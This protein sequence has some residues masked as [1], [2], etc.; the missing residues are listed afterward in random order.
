MSDLKK[1]FV[2]PVCGYNRLCK[3]AENA[4]GGVFIKCK[5]CSNEVEV[6]YPDSYERTTD[7]DFISTRDIK[8]K[9]DNNIYINS[10]MV[11]VMLKNENSRALFLRIDNNELIIAHYPNFERANDGK[12][13]VTW[14]HGIYCGNI[15]NHID[16]R[17]SDVGEEVG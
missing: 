11:L 9:I 5:K 13:Y 15:N 17:V 3:V 8:K 10:G 6:T 16:Y 1:W 4:K 2:C 7:Y 12:T 14:Q